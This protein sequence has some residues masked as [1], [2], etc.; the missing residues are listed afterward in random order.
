M[1]NKKQEL[2]SKIDVSSNRKAA[3]LVIKNGQIID[4]F[5]LEF[6]RG[7]LA[8]V[9][10]TIVGIGKFDGHIVIDAENR[11]I[12]PTF[13]DGHVHIESSMVT[14]EEFAEIVLPHGVAAVITD[15]H[16]I[17]NV[18]GIDG[19][20]FMLQA[21]EN[22]P[23]DIFFMLPS[24]VPATSFENAGAVLTAPDLEPF[25]SHPRVLGLAEVMDYPAVLNSNDGMIE[26]LLAA[27][28][29]RNKID[30]HAAG[31]S[32]E[33]LNSYRT[34]GIQT[35]HECVTAEEALERIKRGMYVL[36]RQGSA[37][38]NLTE[39]IKAVTYKNARR[40]LFCTDDKHLDE[41]ISEGS[42]DYNVRLVIQ[43]GLDPLL[44]IQIASLNAAECYGLTSKGAIAPGYDADF[45]L[46]DNLDDVKISHVFK[47]GKLAAK[48]GKCMLRNPYKVKA[49]T[50]LTTSV[51]VPSITK[52][53]LQIPI[54]KSGL[55]HIIE[56]IPNQLVTKKLIEKVNI[57]DGYFVSSPTDDHLK[58]IVVER[59]QK[60]G[61]IGAGIVKG[62]GL[63]SGAIASTVAHD[64]HNII[65]A[66]TN[67]HDLLKAV[68][69]IVKMKGGLVVVNQGD[70]IGSL[71]L[72]IAGLLSKKEFKEV[73][74]E[75][76]ELHLALK[77]LGGRTNFNPFL[78]LSFLSLPVIPALKLTDLG[79]FDVT[80]F[81]HI[82]V[83]VK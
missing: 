36:I 14:P 17:A 70:V 20:S 46:L 66:G 61:T 80:I 63:K 64:S 48:N 83:A 41:L 21:S 24:C 62:F 81:K 23:I 2:I 34:A 38:K 51:Q 11:Y 6:I 4:V 73:N 72:P 32:P 33:A 59:H 16:E 18:A 5:N 56:V 49:G 13:I 3:D 77:Q 30:G 71:P 43:L 39:L 10:G 27:L 58:L 53:D 69:T 45:L 44:A 28:K 22:L 35:D 47:G 74:E 15:P 7:D 57:K 42:I 68:E 26:K 8:I 50:K 78:T 40:F 54:Y 65:A 60:K 67:D 37:A 19:L 79:L 1:K 9:D 52:K 82:E 75:L 25:Y 55:A 12:A 76:H 29:H 31:L